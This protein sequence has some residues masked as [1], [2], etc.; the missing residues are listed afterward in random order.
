MKEAIDNSRNGDEFPLVIIHNETN[1]IIGSTR[2]L[3]I[4]HVHKRLEIGWTWY[5]TPVWG[6]GINIECKHL[7][8]KYCFETLGFNRVQFK[9]DHQNTRSQ[10][11]I[12]KIG[13]VKEGTLRNHMIRKD[14]TFRHSVF[15]SVII[16]EWYSVK[17]HLEKMLGH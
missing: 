10:K 2:F 13:G 6:K 5:T 1:Q 17:R 15:Y 12:E 4:S 11:A 14:G 8:M 7:L 16:D 3:E 9:T